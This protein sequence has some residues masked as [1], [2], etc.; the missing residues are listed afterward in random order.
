MANK[1]RELCIRAVRDNGGYDSRNPL[2]WNVKV[3]GVD[4]SHKNMVKVA[5]LNEKLK[6]AEWDENVQCESAIENA[7]YAI[8]ESDCYRMINPK[9][10]KKYG[11]D[12]NDMYDVQYGFVGRS[13]GY[14]TITE[15]EGVKLNKWD[16]NELVDYLNPSLGYCAAND[17]AIKLLA[18]IEECNLY[19]TW[20][21]AK[22]E[23]EY[24]AAFQYQLLYKENR[25]REYW[26]SRDIQTTGTEFPYMGY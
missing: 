20:E 19:F 5:G 16:N 22:N 17:W 15:F 26:N 23:I 14:I 7:K 21:N 11:L 25:E 8:T 4:L 13:G 3:R 6:F 1:L 2:A 9:I 10:A 18:F 12:A 24:Q